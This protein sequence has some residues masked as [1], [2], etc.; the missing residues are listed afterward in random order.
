MISRASP[1]ESTALRKHDSGEAGSKGHSGASSVGNECWPTTSTT[2]PVCSQ[3]LTLIPDASSDTV[4]WVTCH[5]KTLDIGTDRPKW[6][7]TH[8]EPIDDRPGQVT[9]AATGCARRHSSGSR[10]D[11]CLLGVRD[12]ALVSHVEG[13]NTESSMRP[14]NALQIE[15]IAKMQK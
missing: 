11:V 5:P 6:V 3:T 14:L 13:L 12:A 15:K 9:A 4:K 2:S 7:E 10:W 8:D 1:S